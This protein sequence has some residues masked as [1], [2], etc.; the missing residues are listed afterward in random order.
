MPQFLLVILLLAVLVVAAYFYNKRAQ[1]RSGDV[2]ANAP[3][4]AP[5]SST[6][7]HDE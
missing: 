5:A 3:A 1:H 7:V 4:E 2:K 6:S